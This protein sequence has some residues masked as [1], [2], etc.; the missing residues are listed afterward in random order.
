VPR[1]SRLPSL[2]PSTLPPAFH[3]QARHQ[4]H[5]QVDRAQRALGQAQAQPGQAQGAARL[6]RDPCVLPRLR[7]AEV[8]HA[9]ARGRPARLHQGA[10]ACAWPPCACAAS[11]R[12]R[13]RPGARRPVRP[14]AAPGARPPRRGRPP[15]ASAAPG[16]PSRPE[17]RAPNPRRVERRLQAG[18]PAAAALGCLP[19]ARDPAPGLR[20][21]R[22]L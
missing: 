22:A 17:R 6:A 21:R 13:A 14:P 18:E 20:P 16:P 9:D 5:R 12:M 4:R 11:A 3:A 10:A 8:L 15:G 2:R 19:L 1:Q 7:A